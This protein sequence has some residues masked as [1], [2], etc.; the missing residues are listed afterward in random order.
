MA[1]RAGRVIIAMGLDRLIGEPVFIWNRL[2][3]PVVLFGRIIDVL[4]GKPS[5]DTL[6]GAI[7]SPWPLLGACGPYAATRR[8]GGGWSG[9]GRAAARAS[10]R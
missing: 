8:L 10:C 5:P 7:T 6:F 1:V 3:H 2:P 9:A 4:S